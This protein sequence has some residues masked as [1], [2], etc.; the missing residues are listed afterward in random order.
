M[1]KS[2]YYSNVDILVSKNQ[3]SLSV[4]MQQLY[5]FLQTVY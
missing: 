4:K 1:T 2:L 5:V 3:V